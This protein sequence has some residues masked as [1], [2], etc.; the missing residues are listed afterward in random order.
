MRNTYQL[1]SAVDRVQP[2]AGTVRRPGPKPVQVTLT[3]DTSH[4]FS[5]IEQAVRSTL[6]TLLRTHGVKCTGCTISNQNRRPGVLPDRCTG[7][8]SNP[9]PSSPQGSVIPASRDDNVTGGGLELLASGSLENE[10]GA[11]SARGTGRNPDRHMLGQ[12]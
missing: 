11:G 4:A 8:E 2:R 5:P 7:R 3:L 9:P 10:D 12:R 1:C 6:K